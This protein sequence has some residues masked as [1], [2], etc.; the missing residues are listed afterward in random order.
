METGSAMLLVAGQADT[1]ACIGYVELLLMLLHRQWSWAGSWGGGASML[2][3]R[4][5]A[6]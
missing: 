3:G 4:A 1:A 2:V 6:F 5:G